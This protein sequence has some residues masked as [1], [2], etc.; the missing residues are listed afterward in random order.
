MLMKLTIDRDFRGFAISDLV[1]PMSVLCMI[2]ER[3]NSK[4]A[5]KKLNLYFYILLKKMYYDF[6]KIKS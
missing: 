1:H 3:H 4:E 2:T 6:A 5:T